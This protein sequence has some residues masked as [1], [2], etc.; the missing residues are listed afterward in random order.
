[1]EV[2]VVVV[3]HMTR[4]DNETWHVASDVAGENIEVLLERCVGTMGR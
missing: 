2:A 4:L 1:M 3:L